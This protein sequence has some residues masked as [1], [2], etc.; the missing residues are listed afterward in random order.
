MTSLTDKQRGQVP[1]LVYDGHIITESAIVA[2]FLADAHP[3]HLLPPS[4]GTE[5][6]LYR[7]RLDWFVDAFINKVNPHIFGGA[8]AA[9][10]EDRDKSAEEL[11]AAVA[12]DLEPRL[13]EGKGPYYGGSETL[14]LAEVSVIG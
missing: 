14:T 7:A 10:E 4:S 6:A 12:K 13:V 9:T 5:N 2:R 1:A 3:S 11:V 8:R